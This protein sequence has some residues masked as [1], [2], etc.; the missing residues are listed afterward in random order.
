MITLQVVPAAAAF[1]LTVSA[2][3]IL[4]GRRDG[5]RAHLLDDLGVDLPISRSAGRELVLQS[6]RDSPQ[7]AA[8]DAAFERASFGERSR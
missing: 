7:F 8:I 2:G 5:D 3:A 6:A 1:L 4:A